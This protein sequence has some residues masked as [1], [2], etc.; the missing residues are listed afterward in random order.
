[1]NAL[2]LIEKIAC[3]AN[4]DKAQIEWL[5]DRLLAHSL[6]RKGCDCHVVDP[7]KQNLIIWPSKNPKHADDLIVKFTDQRFIAM[8]RVDK[9]GEKYW[10]VRDF[11]ENESEKEP[12]TT[13]PS[14][15]PTPEQPPEVSPN[16]PMGMYSQEELERINKFR[17]RQAKAQQLQ[18]QKQ[19]PKWIEG[20]EYLAQLEK[21]KAERKAQQAQVQAH[22]QKEEIKENASNSESTSEQSQSN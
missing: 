16:K 14:S 9:R 21:E 7:R 15:S 4:Q 11:Y 8:P 20:K 22:K 12:E 19:E 3:L 13:S 10:K 17:E 1:M 2:S 18:A 6:P 5:V